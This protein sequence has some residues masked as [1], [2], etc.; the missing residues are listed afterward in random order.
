MSSEENIEIVRRVYSF[1]ATDIFWYPDPATEALFDEAIVWD[2]SRRVF[3]PGVFHGHDG[4]REF[5]TRLREI[6]AS[7]RV[8]PLDFIPVE[9]KVVVP[10]Q[11]ALVSRT[12]GQE[13]TANAAHVWTIRAGKVV[14]HCV[15]QT[16]AEALESVGLSE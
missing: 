1:W 2:V 15:Y 10:V 6:W 3:D 9:D 11:L 13:T 12:H 8:E 5:V 4:I 14:H 7:G 16:K